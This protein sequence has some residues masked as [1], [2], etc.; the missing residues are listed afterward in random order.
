M[1][2]TAVEPEWT[3]GQLLRDRGVALTLFAS[4]AH[5]TAAMGQAVAIG[6]LV[7]DITRKPLDLGYVGLAEFLPTAL[8]VLVAGSVADR[9]DRR[10]IGAI[11]IAF[12]AFFIGALGWFASTG[13]TKVLPI[14]LLVFGFGTA[15]GFGTPATRA[16]TPMVAPPGSLAKVVPLGSTAWQAATIVGPVIA[17]IT[18]AVRPWLPFVVFAVLLAAS[19]F[20]LLAIPLREKQVPSAERPSV[21]HALEGLKFVARTPMLLAAIALD[22]FAVLFG[23]A[24][25]LL[26]AI[27][28]TRL[29]VGSVGLGWL[30]A[31]GGIG[32][33]AVAIALAIRPFGRRVG[34]RLLYS[35]AIFGVATIVL[36]LTRNYA[37]AFVAMFVLMAADMV[38]VFIRGTIVPL[39]TPAFMRGRVL[40]VEAVFIGAS[41]ELGA[42]ESGVA[43]KWLG[44][45]RAIVFGGV[46]TL[47]IVAIWWLVFPA[48]RDVD[49]FEDLAATATPTPNL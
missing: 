21:R 45:S 12:E 13:P 15:R 17:G 43:A 30:R 26:P 37:V 10:K 38:S 42:F 27:S 40:A 2:D 22:L 36:G 34:H 35:V 47:V 8:L 7:F 32:A 6:K 28:G 5:S 48:L 20:A 11:A 14:L 18:Y 19:A 31:A 39:A 44:L 24:V 33:A 46:A 16:L 1:N 25:A 49:S 23:G 29:G 41:N 4:F 9:F 3:A